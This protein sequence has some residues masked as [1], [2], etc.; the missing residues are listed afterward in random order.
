MSTETNITV[1]PAPTAP[2]S[3]VVI[4][5]PMEGIEPP[6][7]K[8]SA[9][10]MEALE[11][12]AKGESFGDIARELNVDRGTIYRWRTYDANFIAALNQWRGNVQS[13]VRD[14]LTAI[15]ENA[16][17]SLK[18][19]IDGGD[20][21]MEIRLLEKMGYVKPGA[22]YPVDPYAIFGNGVEDETGRTAMAEGMRKAAAHM[23]PEQN[24][25]VPQLLALGVVMDNRREGRP[26]SREILEMAGLLSREPPAAPGLALG[27]GEANAPASN[28]APQSAQKSAG[29]QTPIQV[30]VRV[31]ADRRGT[32]LANRYRAPTMKR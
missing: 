27:G 28:G 31:V 30:K 20:S 17:N 13:E 5:A 15:A 6:P 14:R 7:I 16:T 3:T 1:S 10:Q 25:R 8:L 11:M 24:R 19:N 32:G 18:K 22:T 4:P 21:K 23:T 26:S 2:I 29:A 9:Q 12:I